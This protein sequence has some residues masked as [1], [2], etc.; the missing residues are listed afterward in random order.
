[1]CHLPNISCDRRM[2]TPDLKKQA[3]QMAYSREYYANKVLTTMVLYSRVQRGRKSLRMTYTAPDSPIAD[4][5]AKIVIPIPTTAPA[6]NHEPAIR[7]NVTKMSI[8]GRVRTN[9]SRGL[10]C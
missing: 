6:P 7:N 1:M 3:D 10:K 4:D 9:H 5:T 2:V 8:A